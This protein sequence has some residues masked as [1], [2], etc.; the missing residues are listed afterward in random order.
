MRENSIINSI[1]S[2]AVKGS[3]F[4]PE[5]TRALLDRLSAPDKKLKIIHIAGSNGKGSTAAYIAHALKSA[6]LRAG[7]FTS[8]QVYSYAEQ[9][10]VDCLPLPGEKLEKYLEEVSEAA[11]DMDDKP[12][13]FER[14]TAAALLA[15]ERE[16]CGYAVIE[17]G[18]GGL[19]DATN[20][21]A[22]KEVAVITSVS[23]E[24]TAVLGDT[25]SQ[26]CAQK[27]GIIRDC[28]AV[29]SA[30]QSGEGRAYFSA[31]GARFAG[32]GLRVLSEDAEG[33]TF[34]YNGEIYR[35]KMLG[36]AQCYNAATAAEACKLLGLS[37]KDIADGLAMTR[38]KGRVEVIK[39][40]D[41]TYV[42]DGAHNP[43]AFEPLIGSLRHIP[44][45]ITLIY[46]CLSDKD[47][48]N[49]AKI[50]APHFKNAVLVAPNSYRAMETGKIYAAFADKIGDVRTAGSVGEALET[51]RG[52]SVVVC[53]SFTLLKEA[54]E[55]IKR[56]L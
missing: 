1:Q 3:K 54:K 29:V 31:L 14:E 36:R 19:N 44:A 52:A 42:L 39:K 24:H 12:T 51:A 43:A 40:G 10:Q 35:I 8:P 13:A 15:F 55:W 48:K 18:L 34:S 7:L 32:D 16:G 23:L 41:V 49:S 6:G 27:S 50:L 4:G 53:G 56:G 37:Y 38:L 20:A 46:G 26:I 17:C 28:P 21:V 45:P 25:I 22:Q 47:V 9:F 30:L 2:L 33:Q 5:R 11:E